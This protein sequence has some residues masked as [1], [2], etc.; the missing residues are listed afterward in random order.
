MSSLTRM[1]SLKKFLKR[2]YVI[3]KETCINRSLFIYGVCIY[4]TWAM[5]TWD[6]LFEIQWKVLIFPMLNATKAIRNWS[7]R[8]LFEVSKFLISSIGQNRKSGN[9][10]N[11]YFFFSNRIV[12]LKLFLLGLFFLILS[13]I[14]Y[15]TFK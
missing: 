3:E 9:L 15:Q 5:R 13:F 7:K 2:Q 10:I 11:G 8:K 14:Y 6:V 1:S 4:L 12:K